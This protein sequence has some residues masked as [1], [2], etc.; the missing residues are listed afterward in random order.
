MAEN[1]LI[2]WTHNTFNPWMGC[3]KKS[4]GCKNC[5]AETLVVGRMREVELWGP[6]S[7]G[8]KRR[9][10][11]PANWQHPRRWNK[12]AL[13][14]GATMRVFCASLADIFEEHP[15]L[16]VFRDDLWQLVRE[17]PLLQWQILT[18]RPENIARMLPDDWGNYGYHNVWL[19]T[20]IES[21]DAKD[22]GLKSGRV[23]ERAEILASIP[24]ACRFISYE[25]A[26]GPFDGVPLKGI[27][28][29]IFGGES[30]PGYRPMDVQWARDIRERCLQENVQF[31]FKQSA[32][33]RTEM[34][35]QLDGETVRNYPVPRSAM[36][37]WRK[38]YDKMSTP[39]FEA[40][41]MRIRY[42]RRDQ[43][44]APFFTAADPNTQRAEARARQPLP[45]IDEG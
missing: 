45:L 32:A 35:T 10:T 31:F 39:A 38:L 9:K 26:I 12:K 27:D 19:G 17:T 36:N 14:L 33:P 24:A 29:L 1:S 7:A 21:A 6:A 22:A 28:W 42:D 37:D 15:N 2:A 3:V 16:H 25:P 13:E 8:K 43:P 23:A 41:R 30:G 5:Y 4:D 20:S 18:K 40:S 11:S 34:G 44:G